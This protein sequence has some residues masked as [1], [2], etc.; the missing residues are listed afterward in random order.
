MDSLS[1]ELM[2]PIGYKGFLILFLQAFL[3][4]CFIS[5]FNVFSKVK[6]C[7]TP[8]CYMVYRVTQDLD[9]QRFSCSACGA[10]TCTSCH[11]EYHAGITCSMYQSEKQDGGLENLKNWMGKDKKNR[12]RCP[13]CSAL[14]EKN[15]GCNHMTCNACRQHFCWLCLAKCDSENG[16]FMHQRKC[17]ERQKV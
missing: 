10:N 12:K 13:N 4:F 16:F 14:I 8:N 7:P 15:G 11:I 6:Y 3:L 5:H 9:G 2:R 1:T 17:P